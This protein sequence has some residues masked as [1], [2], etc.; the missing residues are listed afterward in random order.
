M[1]KDI[2]K[3]ESLRYLDRNYQAFYRNIEAEA[4]MVF[5]YCI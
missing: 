5:Y 4:T 2:S 3:S 1:D